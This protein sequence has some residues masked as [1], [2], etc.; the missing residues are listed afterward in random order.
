MKRNAQQPK[1]TKNEN[2]ILKNAEH[3]L[4]SKKIKKYHKS[5][6]QKNRDKIL[7]KV[8]KKQSTLEALRKRIIRIEFNLEKQRSNEI[9]K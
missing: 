6:Y 3:A 9:N 1:H 5:Y 8:K 7:E 4:P 2:R